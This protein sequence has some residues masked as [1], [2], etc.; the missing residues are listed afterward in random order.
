MKSQDKANAAALWD[1]L[2]QHFTNAAETIR[3]IIK[4]RAWEPLGYV[5]FAEAWGREMKDVLLAD[6]VRVHVVYQ[7]L[8]ERVPVQDISDMVGGVGPVITESLARQRSNGVP[9]DCAV[10][11]EHLRRPA[12]QASTLRIKVGA[13]ML[14]EYKRIARLQGETVEEIAKEAIAARFAE[15]VAAQGKAKPKGKAS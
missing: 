2:R 5:S 15:I 6:E 9:A 11:R 12:S 3:T 10:V 14:Y 4:D 7:L 1:A 13:T 8:E